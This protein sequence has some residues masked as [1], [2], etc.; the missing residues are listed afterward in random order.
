[1]NRRDQLFD[2]G[3]NLLTLEVLDILDNHFA[4]IILRNNVGHDTFFV[5]MDGD[6]R[7]DAQKNNAGAIFQFRSLLSTTCNGGEQEQDGKDQGDHFHS[8]MF[9]SFS[10]FR[11]QCFLR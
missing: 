10:P 2:N 4:V 9:H 1:M 11:Q 8:V 6:L 3:T 5:I 7:V